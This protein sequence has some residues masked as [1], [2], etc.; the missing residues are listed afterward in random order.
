M[1]TQAA[2]KIVIHRGAD[3][4]GRYVWSPFVTKVEFRLRLSD[5]LYTCGAAG[6]F[7]GPKGK[8]CWL[9]DSLTS[10]AEHLPDTLGRA[11]CP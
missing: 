10:L 5:L 3:R 6:P 9:L 7:A 2:A 4:P 8:V 11:F 1:D